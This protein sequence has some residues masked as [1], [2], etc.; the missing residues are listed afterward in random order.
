MSNK[1]IYRFS[2]NIVF[3]LNI[4]EHILLILSAQIEVADTI[5]FVKMNVK[6]YY[7]RKHQSLTMQI[8]DYTLL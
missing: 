5:D 3:T 2:S 7:D 8:E 4:T 1:T 6:Y